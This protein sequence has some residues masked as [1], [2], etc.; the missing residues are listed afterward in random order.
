MAHGEAGGHA[1]LLLSR[2]FRFDG[3]TALAFL[4]ERREFGL[5]ACGMGR[6]RMFRRHRAEGHSHERIRPRG[7]R[8]QHAGTADVVR[9]SQPHAHALADPIGLHGAHALRP[10]RHVLQG[11]EQILGISRDLEVVHRNFALLDGRAGA[12][13]AA[14]DH[15]LVGEHG[16]IDGIPIDHPCLLVGNAHFQHA[17]KQ[18][19][20]PTVVLRSAGGEFSAPI[21]GEPQG[22]ELS[23]H[24]GD[25]VEGPLR[26]RHLVRHGRIFGGQPEGVPTH[27]LQHVSSVHA[28]ESR[29]YVADGVIAH[30]PHVQEAAWIGEHGQAIILFAGTV[31]F[32]FETALSIPITLGVRLDG[33]R[34]VS[35]LHDWASEYPRCPMAVNCIDPGLR[36]LKLNFY[37][38]FGLVTL[39]GCLWFLAVTPFDLSALAWVAAVPML[40]AVDRAPT[41][42]QA[43]FL[44][45]WA[46]VVETGGGF[47]WLIDV[48]QRFA[49][50]AWWATAPVFLLFCAA[51]AIIFLLFTGIVYGIRQRR[52]VPMTVLA[53]L[54]M[55]SCELVV[56]QLFPCGQ[57]ISQAWQPLVIQ[58]SE[59]TGPLGVTALLMLVNGAHQQGGHPERSR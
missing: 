56:P 43:L 48:M 58:I 33:G 51:H 44:G 31:F 7:K 4:D 12:P 41:F 2:E 45:W 1:L 53:P 6:E 21:Q 52:R 14:I 54:C 16:L 20:V 3:R 24:V 18:P 57:W 32:G 17:Q 37:G 10:S 35:F 34:F 40:L 46:G 26:G 22:F 19:L 8:M 25:I 50:F 59:I 49:D 36:M 28:H 30:M 23:L 47:Y 29:E 13:A 39:S 5:A 38:A 9:K 55:V 11:I 42:R 15:L 27:G